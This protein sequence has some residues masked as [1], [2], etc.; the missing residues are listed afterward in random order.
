MCCMKFSLYQNVDSVTETAILYQNQWLVLKTIILRYWFSSRSSS[1]VIFLCFLFLCVDVFTQYLHYR[2]DVTQGKR[3]KNF[4]A[5]SQGRRDFLTSHCVSVVQGHF[6]V[7]SMNES[8]LMCSRWKILDPI[9]IPQ[10]G[11]SGTKP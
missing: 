4:D 5:D 11:A 3:K 2:Q 8:T 10:M 6:M 9:S 7:E 1:K